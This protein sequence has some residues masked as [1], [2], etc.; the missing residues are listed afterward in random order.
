MS[1]WF[2]PDAIRGDFE[3]TF[4]TLY[5]PPVYSA[6]TTYQIGSR[7]RLNGNVYESTQVVVGVTPPSAQWSLL[8]S[9]CKV[10]YENVP[11]TLDTSSLRLQLSWGDTNNES[12]YHPGGR[13]RRI[14]GVIGVWIFTPKGQGTSKSLQIAA[15]VR[16][17]LNLWNK[18]GTCGKQVMVY[19]VNGPR[20]VDSSADES[21]FLQILSAGLTVFEKLS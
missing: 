4:T 10:L 6:A 21:H 16:Q 15:R 8:G 2:D 14:D 1:N 13:M 18:L 7:V 12:I 5:Y 20:S 19:D 11:S 3:S 9:A 17:T